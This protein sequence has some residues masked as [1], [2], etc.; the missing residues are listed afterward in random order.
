MTAQAKIG[1][2]PD[3]TPTHL[4][5]RCM[6][7]MRQ[8]VPMELTDD[9]GTFRCPRCGLE[10]QPT[11]QVMRFALRTPHRLE[12]EYDATPPDE[13]GDPIAVANSTL[14]L[15]LICTHGIHPH[16]LDGCIDD[17]DALTQ[18]HVDNHHRDDTRAD[19]ISVARRIARFV[20]ADRSIAG[21]VLLSELARAV[22]AYDRTDQQ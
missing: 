15:H 14:W 10:H 18:T 11:E 3:G 21:T 2:A 12:P 5:K 8:P 17:L 1:T 22:H 16:Q 13:R 9:E 20:D 7:S 4:A 19:V 6:G